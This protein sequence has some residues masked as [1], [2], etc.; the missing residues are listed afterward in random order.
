[1]SH[2][3]KKYAFIVNFGIE[4]RNFFLSGL[5][6][7]IAKKSNVV[8]LKRDINSQLFE[9]YAE[10]YKLDTANIDRSLFEKKRHRLESIFQSARQSRMRIK[11]IGVFKNY[12]PK[13]NQTTLK[14]YLKGNLFV[15]TVLKILV[16]K[17]IKEYYKDSHIEDILQKNNITDIVISGYSSTGNLA[18]A[19][20]ALALN[21][22]VWVLVNSWKDFYTNEFIPF[23][24]TGVFV[25]SEEMKKNYLTFNSHL[26]SEQ[27]FVSGNPIFD[28]FHHYSPKQL[29]NYYE[30]KYNIPASGS[31]LLY[32]MLDPDRYPEEIELIKMIGDALVKQYSEE[33]R[34]IIVI[35]R[36]PFNQSEHIVSYFE[37]HPCIR[38]ADHY[39]QRDKVNDFFI[40]STEGEDE[41]MDLLYYSSLNMGAA[42]TVA[43]EA[44][45]L[46]KPVVTIAFDHLD[47]SSE[48]LSTMAYT[49]FYKAIL[50]REDVSLVYSCDECMQGIGAFIG[51]QKLL[52]KL[53][54]ILNDE[55]GRAVMNIAN[56]MEN[57]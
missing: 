34:P 53:P 25:W 17:Q 14:D 8:V 56:I 40:Q 39:S 2:D 20:N 35:R 32:S 12:N 50:E 44:I 11:K 7:E 5:S 21:L 36:N 43:L 55:I 26:K 10:Q 1:M 47:K 41:W 42:S 3:H 4:Y 31:I 45:M 13:T 54:T 15:Y 38:V 9:E 29:R 27:F 18:F 57:A 48:L 46:K 6:S 19:T 51:E 23:D 33:L 37:G 16:L 24:P 28:R 52:Y 30:K 22:N 49:P